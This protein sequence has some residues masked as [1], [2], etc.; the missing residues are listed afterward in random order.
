MDD[1]QKNCVMIAVIA[2]CVTVMLFMW[3]LS[4]SGWYVR[5]PV[6]LIV[7]AAVGGGAYKAADVLT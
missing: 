7:A 4:G 3:L 6:T 5:Y 2:F 1:K